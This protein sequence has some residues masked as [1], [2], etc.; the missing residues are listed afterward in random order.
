[1]RRQRF[2]QA[3]ERLVQETKTGSF[4]NIVP[5]I[6][7]Q[8][9]IPIISNSFRIQQIFAEE[10]DITDEVPEISQS[11]DEDLTNDEQIT[12]EWAKFIGYPMPDKHSLARVSQ[13]HLVEEAKQKVTSYLARAKYI[14]FMKEFILRVFADDEKY[15]GVV[16]DLKS[17]VRERSFSDIVN[18]LELPEFP[19][20]DEDPLLLLARLPLPIYITTSYYDFLERALLEV[21]K[22][23]ITQICFW[24]GEI[25]DIRPEHRTD[26]DFTP[27]PKNPLVYHLYG[28]EDYPETMVLSE[29]DYMNFLVEVMRHTDNL[30][31]IVPSS[32][33]EAL[34]ESQLLLLGYQLGN[35]DFRVLFR[36][37]SK[38]RV[39]N[40]RSLERGMVI[41]LKELSKKE[42]GDVN[43]TL[44]YLR[45]YF[46]QEN[47]EVKWGNVEVFIRELCKEWN[48][49]WSGEL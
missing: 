5:L 2:A 20:N 19:A 29:D 37:L 43:K 48:Q 34:P 32:L 26:K 4:G 47:F 46:D 3:T 7:Q 49:T 24:S 14:H 44:E 22:K 31:P 12:T 15:Q 17:A 6:S 13:Y 21:N 9:V 27:S 18:D 42:M 41:Q 45:E 33:R 36:F 10:K 40:R 39:G 23:P 38:F 25:K 30:N 1:M 35:W 16:S 11:E 8:K 28:F